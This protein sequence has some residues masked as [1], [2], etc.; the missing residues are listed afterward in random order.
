VVRI[1]G[2]VSSVTFHWEGP[3]LGVFD[4]PSCASKVRGIQNFH[5]DARDWAD[6]AYN[7]VVCPHGYVFEGRWLGARSA[8]QGTNAGNNTSYAICGL[9]GQGDPFTDSGRMAYLECRAYFMANGAGR[10]IHPH[11]YWHSTD[12]PGDAC[13]QWIAAG[14]PSPAGPVVVGPSDP[15]PSDK[16]VAFSI[17]GDGVWT[18][19]ADGGVFSEGAP[20]HGS[21]GGTPLAKPIV[22]GAS[23]GSTGYWL[24]GADGGV[25][26]FGSAPFLGG[27]GG[28]RLN[29]PIVAVVPSA[30]RDG[31]WMF[32]ADGGVFSFG[33]AGFYGSVPPTPLNQPISCAAA[34][35]SGNGYWLVAKDGGVFAF[36]GASYYGSLAGVR[37]N[38]PIVAVVPSALGRGYHLVGADGGIFSFGDAPVVG[39]YKPLFQE[40]AA[41]TRRVVSALRTLSGGLV[42]LSNLGE[43]YVL[44]GQ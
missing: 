33:T 13:R 18:Y 32:A 14:A 44:G 20:F 43:R 34:T 15:T 42:L 11:S 22:A 4:H 30:G 25:F 1:P 41:G 26:T 39:P 12:C 40:Y 38:A 36:G 9:W 28:A 5:M 16:C 27:T 2:P 35:P 19:A 17:V 31:Y 8:A 10:G 7:A 37:L 24:F 21:M 23:H 29:H 3:K 6:I